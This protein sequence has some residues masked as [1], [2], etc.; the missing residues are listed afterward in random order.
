MTRPRFYNLSSRA[1][2]Q[3]RAR[4][5]KQECAD[6]ALV[7]DVAEAH[8]HVE[9]NRKPRRLT[10]SDQVMVR[11]QEFCLGLSMLDVDTLGPCLVVVEDN[12]D[13]RP[14]QSIMRNVMEMW[15]R[16]LKAWTL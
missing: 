8:K 13:E 1:E 4:L 10:A 15:E 14:L 5:A 3:Y 6:F 7:R 9:L 2:D 11:D 12:G 16:L